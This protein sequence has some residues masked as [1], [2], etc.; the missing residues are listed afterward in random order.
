M[1]TNTVPMGLGRLDAWTRLGTAL[2]GATTAQAALEQANLANWNVRKIDLTAT[3]ITPQGVTTLAVPDRFAS[4]FTNPVTGQTQYLGVVGGHYTPIQNEAHV[5]LLDALISE[6][7]VTHFDVAGSFRDGRQVFI[8]MRMPE[9]L[10]IGG[11]DRVDLYLVALNSH[12]GSST[13]KFIVTPVRMSCMNMLAAA[14]SQAVASFSIRHTRGSGGRIAEARQALGLTFKYAEEFE[15][16][17]EKM[18][19]TS[20]TDKSF[21]KVARR[22]SGLDATALSKRAETSARRM[23]DGLMGTWEGSQTMDKIKGTR[24]AG[25]QAVTEFTDHFMDVRDTHGGDLDYARA[26]RAVAN[27]KMIK[28]KEDAF[29]TFSRTILV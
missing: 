1:T 21:Q 3:E 13:F 18:I 7:G 24:W 20:L 16:A 28:F 25:Y 26:S 29:A 5:E 2:E 8:T 11:V 12:D 22:L 27:P 10:Q 23:F 9:S 15:A 17:A 4:V 19:Q 6:A 14:L